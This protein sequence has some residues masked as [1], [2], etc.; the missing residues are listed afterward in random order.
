VVNRRD[1]YDRQLLRDRVYGDAT[2]GDGRRSLLGVLFAMSLFLLIL[3][4]SARQVT[5]PANSVL[6]L[7]SGI[8]VLTD[9][10]R[11][12]EDEAPLLREQADQSPNAVFAIPD[13]PLPIAVNR[14]ELLDLTDAELVDRLLAR[15]A[16]L[17]Y[18]EGI[19]A[20]DT[21]GEQSVNRFSSEGLLEFAVA[22][23]SETNYDRATLGSIIFALATAGLGVLFVVT[24]YGWGRLRGL[25]FATAAG[26]L[27]GIGIFGFLSWAANQLGG[28]DVFMADLREIT[29]AGLRVPL[30][31]FGIV[32]L[33]GAVMAAAGIILGFAEGKLSGGT[34][35]VFEPAPEAVDE[36][37]L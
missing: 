11:L 5:A 35:L 16:A 33:A 19:S 4:L 8:A 22:Q 2:S 23:A 1:E 12:V 37:A 7:E 15:S 10:E 3:S 13:Y 21:T 28:S 24:S 26:A 34:A 25:G 18:V 29:R 31:N 36:D 6:M 27:P 17:V 32:F 30:L 14:E 9:I 20:F